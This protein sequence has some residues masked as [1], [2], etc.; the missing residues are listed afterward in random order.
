MLTSVSKQPRCTSYTRPSRPLTVLHRAPIRYSLSTFARAE[1][2]QNVTKLTR[3]LILEVCKR[4]PEAGRQRL[5]GNQYRRRAHAAAR[6]ETWTACCCATAA[7]AEK[8][9]G[10][11]CL[12]SAGKPVNM[13]R[14]SSAQ[15]GSIGG[16]TLWLSQSARPAS[17]T[18]CEI[19]TC[20]RGVKAMEQAR[21]ES[22][23][24][25]H[26]AVAVRPAEVQQFRKAGVPVRLLLRALG[27]PVDSERC[28][29]RLPM[30]RQQSCSRTGAA[31][32]LAVS[33][34][35]GTDHA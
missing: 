10:P 8:A 18:C 17:L 21:A 26:H 20:S 23:A 32:R 19:L 16:E 34:H 2:E 14:R 4:F 25:A 3:R 30:R 13:T 15:N 11:G 6:H 12:A 9:K 35:A 28:Q 1:A 5:S 7:F 29:L 27:G 24:A 31:S 22:S 33:Q